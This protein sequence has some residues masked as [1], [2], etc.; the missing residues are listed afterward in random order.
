MMSAMHRI[1]TDVAQRVVHPTHVPLVAEAQATKLK[2]PRHLRPRSRFFRD[3]R[4]LRK[5][6]EHLLIEAAQEFDGI[7]IF[8]AAELI[9]YP[10]S[11]GSAV[12]EVKHRCDSIDP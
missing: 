8:S 6:P 1:F 9:R 4:R 12:V 3:G 7:Q 10:T 11:H 5:P 2:R